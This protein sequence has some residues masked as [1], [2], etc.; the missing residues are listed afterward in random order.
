MLSLLGGVIARNGQAS[1]HRHI[2]ENVEI[3]RGAEIHPA[4]PVDALL[5]KVSDERERVFDVH[6]EAFEQSATPCHRRIGEVFAVA[7]LDLNADPVVMTLVVPTI[8]D[9]FK[10]SLAV[11]VRHEIVVDELDDV[12]R[13]DAT[14]GRPP[15]EP[16]VD[17]AFLTH[18]LD[19]RFLNHE[20]VFLKPPEA[21][22]EFR[23][24]Y[25]LAVEIP[26]ESYDTSSMRITRHFILLAAIVTLPM[27]SGQHYT[28][29]LVA[30]L[31]S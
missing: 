4:P 16:E 5:G 28:D 3:E 19:Q 31:W 23:G 10:I 9:S 18:E 17:F 27:Q 26:D 1:Q 25:R 14:E 21:H 22:W 20:R 29:L 11:C 2:S 15:S 24:F 6:P 8:Q 7:G 13:F 30:A 12:P